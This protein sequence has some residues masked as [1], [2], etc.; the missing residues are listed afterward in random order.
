[1]TPAS[2]AA[3]VDAH[4]H[5]DKYTDHELSAV[6]DEI[7]RHRILTISVSDDPDAYR[8]ARRI[9]QQSRFV[10]A[11]FGIHPWEA[12]RFAGTIDQ[13]ADELDT[14]PMIGEIGL[15]H[16]FVTD[17]AAHQA[18]AEVFATLLDHAAEHR[19]TVNIHSSGAEHEVAAMLRD[20]RVER[21][22]LHWY[23][24]PLDVLRQLI[25]RDHTVHHRDRD[26]ALRTHPTGRRPHP[27]RAAPDRNRQPRRVPVAHRSHG[28]AP[29]HHARRGRACRGSRHHRRPDPR[30]GPHQPPPP[31]PARPAPRP[32]ATAAGC[33]RRRSAR[34]ELQ[35][36]TARRDPDRRRAAGRPPVSAVIYSACL[37]V[38]AGWYA[39]QALHITVA[40]PPP[41][42]AER[43]ARLAVFLE[44][45][46]TTVPQQCGALLLASAGFAAFYVLTERTT[47]I[48][49]RRWPARMCRLGATLFITAQ[50]IQLGGYRHLY[51][52]SP[53]SGRDPD[54]DLVTLQLVDAID[55]ALELGAFT[56][57][58]AGMLGLGITSQ[59]HT[60]SPRMVTVVHIHRADL[61]GARRRH[62][63]RR[64]DRR[65]RAAHR[66][67]HYRGTHL[68]SHARPGHSRLSALV[69][70]WSQSI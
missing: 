51:E 8:R 47:S 4:A 42:P 63:C 48:I 14:S 56:L 18:Q 37:V 45:F 64:M 65:R 58:A 25:H 38:A 66:R 1:M 30:T 10:I 68:G 32:M 24:G 31:R 29:P 44:Y 19:K 70:W 53:T 36:M 12:P 34:R 13:F 52:T 62:G 21:A 27:V 15:D 22:I 46:R 57:L 35:H 28:L 54:A 40:S 67:R 43:T 5:L 39:L 33:N 17:P 7:D 23:A 61:S 16:R 69:V 60:V 9:A 3:H 49:D 6:L 26:P 20:R 41:L 59:R 50:L 2:R 11:T 55:D